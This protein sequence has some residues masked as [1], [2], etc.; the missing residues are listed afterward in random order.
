MFA[1]MNTA[2]SRKVAHQNRT[3]QYRKVLWVIGLHD[4]LLRF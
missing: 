1:G 3:R 2:V 4:P